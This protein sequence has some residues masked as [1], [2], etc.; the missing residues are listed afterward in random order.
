MK[1]N[2]LD[3]IVVRQR[4][5]FEKPTQSFPGQ[6]IVVPAANGTKA[7]TSLTNALTGEIY[8]LWLPV[9]AWQIKHGR[10]KWP[11][12]LPSSNSITYPA[13]E[14]PSGLVE[15]GTGSIYASREDW[16]SRM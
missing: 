16:L 6:S 1:S 11:I 9:V 7:Y 8:D 2:A 13:V 3:K 5:E 14:Y 10:A 4:S 12:T 15:D